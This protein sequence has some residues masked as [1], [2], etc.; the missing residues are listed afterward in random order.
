MDVAYCKDR[1]IAAGVS[2]DRGLTSKELTAIEK[3][4]GFVFPPDL[5]EFLNYA[6]PISPRWPEWRASRSAVAK[7][8]EWPY[9][10]MCFDIQRNSFWLDSWG[11]KPESF[12]EAC[13]IAR[14]ALEAAPRL[15]PV[16]VHRYLPALPCL[17]GNPV[18][19]VYQTDIIYYGADLADY[20]CNEFRQQFGRTEHAIGANIRLIEFWS[21]LVG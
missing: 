4:F 20:F 8:L 5:K 10:G 17:P 3:D 9:D 15:I 2:F 18:F 12:A 16:Y 13:S 6:L 21:D 11:P 19:S 1:L 14:T 7:R